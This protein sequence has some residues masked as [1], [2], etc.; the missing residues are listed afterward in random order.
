MTE[1]KNNYANAL[2]SLS[3]S[4]NELYEKM[5]EE[6]PQ[7]YNTKEAAKRAM[8]WFSKEHSDAFDDLV[9]LAGKAEHTCRCY[10]RGQFYSWWGIDEEDSPTGHELTSKDAW[11]ASRWPK[12]VLC[13]EIA[14]QLLEQSK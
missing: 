2:A 3:D 6:R 12:W 1:L 10:G 8:L 11:P 13:T 4:L 5:R 7:K 9:L 14:N